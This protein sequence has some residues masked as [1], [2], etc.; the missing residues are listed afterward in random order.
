VSE[1]DPRLDPRR[2]GATVLDLQRCPGCRRLLDA[3]TTQQWV[4]A[5]V[6]FP[7]CA[8]C[9]SQAR[10]DPAFVDRLFH[11]VADWVE[12]DKTLTAFRRDHADVL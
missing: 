9:R 5:G 11:V 1:N 8:V 2:H 10:S 3:A 6:S 7:I 4:S 12:M